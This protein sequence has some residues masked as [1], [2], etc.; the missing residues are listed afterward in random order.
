[1]HLHLLF[2]FNQACAKQGDSFFFTEIQSYTLLHLK[3]KWQ[4]NRQKEHKLWT[5]K[6]TASLLVINLAK[7]L[8]KI[9]LYYDYY[10]RSL[11]NKNARGQNW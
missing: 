5:K 4:Q 10:C 1:M 3:Y 11:L 6:T 2:Q 8:G 7:W 9:Q